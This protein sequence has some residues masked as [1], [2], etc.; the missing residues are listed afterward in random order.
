MKRLGLLACDSLWEPLR[1]GF[2]DYPEM[3]TTLFA[4]LGAEVT[5]EVFPV[6]RGTLPASVSA[7]DCW[8]ISGSRAGVYED[9]PWIAPLMDFSRAAHA[10][11]VPQVGVCFGHQLLAQALGG[12]TEK[13]PHGWGLG[14][15]RLELLA[16]PDWLAAAAA[17]APAAH[18]ASGSGHAPAG[19]RAASR[20]QRA[21]S[22][23][24]VRAR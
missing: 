24:D 8:L 11:G 15:V 7:C 5:L 10:A 16:R 3:F 14:N 2:G 9:L 18:G 1:T 23:R 20:H 6:Y 22:L 4:A 13:A 19:A 17:F 12:R 21:L